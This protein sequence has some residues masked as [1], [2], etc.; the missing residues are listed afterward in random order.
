MQRAAISIPSNIAEG[1]ARNNKGE[2]IQFLGIAAGSAAELET[3]L[4]LSKE[5]FLDIDIA[6]TLNTLKEIQKMLQTLI[7]KLKHK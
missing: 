4:L 2:F 7:T 5:L 6:Q 1:C 3:Q